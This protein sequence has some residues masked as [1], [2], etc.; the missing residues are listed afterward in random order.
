MLKPE[1]IGLITLYLE[2]EKILKLDALDRAIE[3]N[4]EID[5]PLNNYKK[6]LL[7]LKDFYN[8]INDMEKDNE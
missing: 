4:S 1:T 2:N 5:F 8:F 6:I 3:N 7:A